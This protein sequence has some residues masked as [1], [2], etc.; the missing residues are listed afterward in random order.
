VTAP[1][2][3]PMASTSASSVR[4]PIVLRKRLTF[5]NASLPVSV[6]SSYI[7]WTTLKG[8]EDGLRMPRH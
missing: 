4:A 8:A 3:L 7:S 5:E 1:S 6:L 2:A